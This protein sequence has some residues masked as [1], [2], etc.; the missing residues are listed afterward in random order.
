MPEMLKNVLAGKPWAQ[1][2][3]VW[4]LIVFTAIFAGAN[5]ACEVGLLDA[6]LCLRIQKYG[7]L[8]GG[9][10]VTLGIRKA[11]VAKNIA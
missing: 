1:S 6:E 9:W 10:L 11:A 3:T 8:V 4:G 5:E 2:L 7:A